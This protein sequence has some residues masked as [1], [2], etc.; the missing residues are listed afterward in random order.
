MQMSE[1]RTERLDTLDE[2]GVWETIYKGKQHS[3]FLSGL[4]NGMYRF[5]VRIDGTH[6]DHAVIR[7]LE[8]A[9]HPLSRAV[10]L[11]VIGGIVFLSLA[12]AIIYWSV[13]PSEPLEQVS[14]QEA[15]S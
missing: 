7:R 6:A 15:A 10:I 8:I 11:L 4:P 5:R 9:H 14:P 12:A 2:R 1:G 13:R 3:T